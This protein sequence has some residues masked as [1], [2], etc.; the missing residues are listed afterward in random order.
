MPSMRFAP[1][2][3]VFV[4]ACL[5]NL[6]VFA[7]D[8]L[9]AGTHCIDT[10][11]PEAFSESVTTFWSGDGNGFVGSWNSGYAV[12]WQKTETAGKD[13]P[14]QYSAYLSGMKIFGVPA[15]Q[16]KL[17]VVAGKLCEIEIMFFNKGDTASRLGFGS[18]SVKSRGEKKDFTEKQWE[19]CADE[20]R[21]ILGKF[22]KARR[23]KIGSLK[24][25]RSVEIWENGA[26]A[27]LL[28]AQENEF[29]RV[30]VVPSVQLKKLMSSAAER[31]K[32]DLR[33]NVVRRPNGDVLVGEIPMVDQGQKGY[34][35][36]ATIE[37]VLRYY[38]ISELDMHKIAELAETNVG[39]GTTMPDVVRGVGPVVKK[40]RLKFATRRMQFAKIRQCVDKG[41][42]MFWCMFA[43]PDYLNRLRANTLERAAVSDFSAFAKKLKNADKL[44]IPRNELMRHAH[45]CLIIGYNSKTKEVCV[46][47]S[48]GDHTAEQWIAFEDA[49]YVTQKNASLYILEK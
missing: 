4:V 30:L 14:I 49:L 17:E 11:T 24:L 27:F 40:N 25:R 6:T 20:I 18:E 42:P 32:G 45:V 41:I 22:G 39:G 33:E 48:W 34:C 44:E 31:A 15:E 23:G 5:L 10:K 28:D 38:G 29:V 12:H 19:K 37:R 47:D 3:S 26:N 35:V 16:I 43:A 7:E 36:P 21:R 13:A 1:I 9:M 46:S 2:F 8:E